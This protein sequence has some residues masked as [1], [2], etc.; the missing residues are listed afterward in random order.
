MALFYP[1]SIYLSCS[2]HYHHINEGVSCSCHSYTLP[3][4]YISTPR[5]YMQSYT[6]YTAYWCALSGMALLSPMS[7]S[8]LSILLLGLTQ[9][10]SVWLYVA[11][12]SNRDMYIKQ[13]H[14]RTNCYNRATKRRALI[15]CHVT[16]SSIPH[17]EMGRD[18][19]QRTISLHHNNVHVL[20]W[21]FVR[22]RQKKNVMWWCLMFWFVFFCLR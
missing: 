11:S 12:W 3:S 13:T 22:V 6:T 18:V 19:T 7:I 2:C 15:T 10:M 21:L 8:P 14:T 1:L 20:S 5:R 9:C 16:N 4:S 17:N